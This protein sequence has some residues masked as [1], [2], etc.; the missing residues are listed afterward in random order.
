MI[1][2]LDQR[3]TRKLDWVLLSVLAALAIFPGLGQNRDYISHEILHAEIVREMAERGDFV[4][5]KLLGQRFP[6]K[7]PVLHAPAA[8][9]MRWVGQPSILLVRLPV[10]LVGMLGILA[11]YEVGRVLLDRRAALVGAIVLLAIPG[12]GLL[13]R[14]ALP[15]MFLCTGMTFSCLWLLL[16]MRAPRPVDRTLYF[17]MAGAASGVAILAKGPFG[18]V[19]PIFFTVFS[20]FGH[21]DLKRPRLGWIAF[22][23]G[24]LAAMAI[25]A[26]P[27][28][29]LDHG[30]YLREVVFQ[31]DLHWTTKDKPK[32]FLLY[33]YVGFLW[34]LPLS[35]FLPLAILDW[36]RHA[37]SPFLAVAV[38]IL[39]TLSFVPK[40]R[41]HYV[42][43]VFPFLAL[44]VGATI[45]R[46]SATNRLVRWTA[47]TLAPVS[48][49]ALPLY[50]VAIQP[51]MLPKEDPETNFAKEVLSVVGTN[52]PLYCVSAHPE[53]LAWVARRYDG[54]IDVP[55]KDARVAEQL[56]HASPGAY[57]LTRRR[58]LN[59]LLRATGPLPLEPVLER[60]VNKETLVLFR[61]REQEELPQ[62]LRESAVRAVAVI[63]PR[64][65]RSCPK[66]R[67]SMSCG[68]ASRG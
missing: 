51:H 25:W 66:P 56:R 64:E 37:Y 13:A 67:R 26:V 42:L 48:L 12:Y 18:L 32:P 33:F 39:L 52:G 30:A 49:A 43:P 3:R 50:F 22:A 31:P 5:T 20:A 23:V 53:V 16:G 44:G 21:T 6:D 15:D 63:E 47:W 45:V 57:L 10:A 55:E 11:A 41:D 38:A 28:Y 19:F 9:L 46:H 68:G 61:F 34:A 8:L 2:Y 24:M 17:I 4:E 35:L 62:R 29:F 7:P 27:A 59:A 58:S 1:A 65:E 60:R 36:R 14:E 54:F 40:K